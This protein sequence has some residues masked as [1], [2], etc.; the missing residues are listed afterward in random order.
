MT[1]TRNGSRTAPCPGPTVCALARETLAESEAEL[2]ELAAR[3]R[4]AY[5]AA[6]DALAAREQR[7]VALERQAVRLVEENRALRQKSIELQEA[8][9]RQD[10]ECPV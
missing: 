7:A 5:T 8:L 2:Q 9:R 6:V 10:E 3:Y 4:L 1:L